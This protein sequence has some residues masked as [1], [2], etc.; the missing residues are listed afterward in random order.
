MTRKFVDT[1]LST[2]SLL[3]LTG[4]AGSLVAGGYTGD[5]AWIFG[6]LGSLGA[7]LVYLPW[8]FSKPP[9]FERPNRA[10]QAALYRT[11]L[12][13]TLPAQSVPQQ[14]VREHIGRREQ[15]DRIFR[16]EQHITEAH[17]NTPGGIS[18]ATPEVLLEIRDLA[19]QA[20]E[21]AMRRVGL[22]RAL[23]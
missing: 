11:A 10:Q 23:R 5:P 18:V 16:L 3:F 1:L 14:A 2:P 4:A 12:D 9:G 20:F 17:A 8:A 21:L 7:W 13:Q 15:L 6:V 19:N 22:L